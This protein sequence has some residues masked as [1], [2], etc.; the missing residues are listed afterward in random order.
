MVVYGFGDASADGFGA[1]MD[2][3]GQGLFGRF[4]IWGKD[5]ED[6]SS[7]YR[8]LRNLVETVE[9]EAAEEYLE[10]GEL[11]IFTDNLTAESCVHKGGSTSAILHE[12][13]V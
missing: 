5:A 1:T 9:E 3:P 11:W 4:G 7:N 8:E 10:G 13:V 12:L 2:R 6:G